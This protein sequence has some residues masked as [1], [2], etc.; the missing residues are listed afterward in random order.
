MRHRT[1]SK[2]ICYYLLNLVM[3]TLKEIIFI[4]VECR[5]RKVMEYYNPTLQK[6]Y[7][8]NLFSKSSLSSIPSII[9]K[10]G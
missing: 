6:Q 9:L 3:Y 10:S 1:R 5:E 2:S 4:T 7:C 8:S